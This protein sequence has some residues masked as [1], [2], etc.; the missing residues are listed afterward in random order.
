MYHSELVVPVAGTLVHELL[1]E[2]LREGH[3]GVYMVGGHG[4][5]WR[6]DQDH[7]GPL[8]RLDFNISQCV[9]EVADSMSPVDGYPAHYLYLDRLIATIEM[10]WAGLM[11]EW[12]LVYDRVPRG[13]LVISAAESPSDHDSGTSLMRRLRRWFGPNH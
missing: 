9:R 13:T 12:N 4:R 6:L 1:T 8:E 3:V 11:T 10:P 2:M 5:R 7:Y